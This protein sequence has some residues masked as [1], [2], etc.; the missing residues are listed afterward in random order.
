MTLVIEPYQ[1]AHML[2]ITMQAAQLPELSAVPG[3]LG[4][5]AAMGPAFTAFLVEHGGSPAAQPDPAMAESGLAGSD[6][7][8]RPRRVVACAGLVVNHSRYATAWAVFAEGNGR[9]T[10]A[11]LV[12]AIQRVLAA[13]DYDRVDMMVRD[14]FEA[15][16]AFA[17]RLGFSQCGLLRRYGEDGSD[18]AVYERVR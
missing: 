10:W 18:F 9:S 16:H 15:G 1:P 13:A 17:R 6:Q 14:A 5:A 4:Q 3:K 7:A 12:G 8:T 11:G 2:A